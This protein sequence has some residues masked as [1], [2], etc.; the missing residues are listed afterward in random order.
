MSYRVED[1]AEAVVREYNRIKRDYLYRD[2]IFDAD[3]ELV[4]AIKYILTTRLSIVDKTFLI[5]Y[6]ECGAYRKMGEILHISHSSCAKIMKP[7]IDKIRNDRHIQD[8]VTSRCP[9]G[10]RD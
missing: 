6:A 7:I 5:I 10:L 2:D 1:T 4:R 3:D 8:I 9:R